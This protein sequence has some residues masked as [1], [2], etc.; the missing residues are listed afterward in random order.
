MVALEFISDQLRTILAGCSVAMPEEATERIAALERQLSDAN[1]RLVAEGA[2][3]VRFDAE[4]PALAQAV[5][6]LQTRFDE[7]IVDARAEIPPNAQ[8][9]MVDMEKRLVAAQAELRETRKQRDDAV[10]QADDLATLRDACVR[11]RKDAYSPRLQ[12]AIDAF[13]RTE[14]GKR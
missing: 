8:A 7:M 3:R 12:S 5:A 11:W 1:A 4:L 6:D 2:A 13:L 9:Q 10:R 14:V